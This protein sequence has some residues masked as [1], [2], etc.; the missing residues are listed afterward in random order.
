[1]ENTNQ[2]F[3]CQT[4]RGDHTE[5]VLDT[6]GYFLNAAVYRPNSTCSVANAKTHGSSAMCTQATFTPPPAFAEGMRKTAD[7]KCNSGRAPSSDLV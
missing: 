7:T 1:M 4:V 5:T 6:S 2:N 3:L